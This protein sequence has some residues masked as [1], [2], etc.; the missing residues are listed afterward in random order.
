[1]YLPSFPRYALIPEATLTPAPVSSVTF[2]GARKS[3]MRST[4]A[5]GE[6]VRF[7][8]PG[9]VIVWGTVGTET[10]IN[11][12]QTVADTITG[13]WQ[14]QIRGNQSITRGPVTPIANEVNR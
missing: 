14:V 11:I 5:E 2:P 10:R 6:I 4:A 9:V 13:C 1:M 7:V 12:R 8:A 3:A